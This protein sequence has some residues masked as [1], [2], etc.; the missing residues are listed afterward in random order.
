MYQQQHAQSQSQ[1][2]LTSNT[3]VDP[4]EDD[5]TGFVPPAPH[6]D[7]AR[8]NKWKV[9]R[10]MMDQQKK[11]QRRLQK[12]QRDDEDSDESNL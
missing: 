12:K 1:Y 9:N 2:Q 6:Q 7:A 5:H 4:E 11:V 8:L 10:K 3:S